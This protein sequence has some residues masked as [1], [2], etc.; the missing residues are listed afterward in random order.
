MQNLMITLD[1]FINS[2]NNFI[3]YR[4]GE[5]IFRSAG[6][7]LTPLLSFIDKHGL[8]LSG[9]VLF[10]RYIGR[11]AALLMSLIGPQEVFTGTISEGGAELL[12]NAGIDYHFQEKVT[13]LMGVASGEMCQWEKKSLGKSAE[14]F[15][16]LLTNS[17]EPLS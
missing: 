17:E 1:E 8:H 13:Y 6:N 3:A 12:Q 16:T 15:Y 10:D 5:D 2:D 14:E 4:N 7:D 9:L 11:A